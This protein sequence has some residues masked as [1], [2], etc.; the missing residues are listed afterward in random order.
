MLMKHISPYLVGAL[1]IAAL[2][3]SHGALAHGGGLDFY[4]C[5]H[6]NRDFKKDYR[7]HR[8]WNTG[9]RFRSKAAML[10]LLAEHPPEAKKAPKKQPTDPATHNGRGMVESSVWLN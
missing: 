4:G 2:V 10:Q 9:Q 1:A 6:D 8:G 3:A 7:C 5:H